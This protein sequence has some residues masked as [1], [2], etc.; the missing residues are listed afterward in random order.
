MKKER[1]LGLRDLVVIG[2]LAS[3]CV[4]ATS[5]KIPFGS[6]AMIHLGTACIFTVGL[7]FGGVYAGLAAAVGSAFFDLLM[8]FSPYTIWSF[9]IKGG[10][11]FIVGTVARGKWPEAIVGEKWLFKAASGMALA[12]L[13]TLAGYF[14]AWW[15]VSGS[16]LIA[17][18]NIPSS[19]LTSAAGFAAALVVSPKLRKALRKL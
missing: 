5:L 9:F 15:L 2:M 3:L 16:L 19:L 17:L 6:G 1:S 4:I 11:G 12:S 8:G 13:W 14:I 18:N 10:A 7:L